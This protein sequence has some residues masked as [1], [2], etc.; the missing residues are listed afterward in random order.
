MGLLTT[1]TLLLSLLI[2]SV[3]I[4]EKACSRFD[5]EPSFQDNTN[6]KELDDLEY[7]VYT[8]FFGTENLPTFELPEYFQDAIQARKIFG[9]TELA[10]PIEQDELSLLKKFFGKAVNTPLKDYNKKNTTEYMVKDRMKDSGM[11]VFT[12]EQRDKLFS[13][14]LSEVPSHVT[15]EFVSVSGIGF[16]ETKDTA[17]FMITL[18]GSAVTSYYVMMQ[19]KENKWVIVNAIMESIVI[20]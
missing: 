12:K 18:N 11:I 7:A 4:P 8:D 1:P 20:F 17:F 9:T 5:G 3:S 15:G 19:K 14:G 6:L 10:K 16:N 2:S 13:G